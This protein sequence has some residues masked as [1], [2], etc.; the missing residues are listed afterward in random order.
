MSNEESDSDLILKVA[1]YF[2]V[3][4]QGQKMAAVGAILGNA[5]MVIGIGSVSTSPSLN[6]TLVLVC[7]IILLGDFVWMLVSYRASSFLLFAALTFTI[8]G[9]GAYD[10]W[11]ENPRP[12]VVPA[13]LD[14]IEQ[15]GGRSPL[16]FRPSPHGLNQVSVAG[17]DSDVRI[18]FLSA[19]VFT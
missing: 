6:A 2:E 4:K 7:G 15:R 14:A 19:G 9:L 12:D 5:A 11:T 1:R 8:A 17:I 16:T 18:Q 3:L 10:V 13:W